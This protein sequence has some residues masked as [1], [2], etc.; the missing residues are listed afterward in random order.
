[1]ANKGLFSSRCGMLPKADARNAHGAP[2]YAFAPKHALAQYAA[3][4]CLN[5]TFYASA[6]V[7]L[8]VMLDLCRSVDDLFLARTALF[9]RE[10]GYMTDMPALLCALLSKRDVA[11]LERVFPRVIDN[12]KMLRNFV[13]M[14][15]SGVAG[16]RS[17]GS[18]PR[19]MVRRFLE[20]RDDDTLF[21]SSAGEDPSLADIVALAHPKP[22]TPEREAL[23]AY[24][25]GWAR[26]SPALPTLVKQYEAFKDGDSLAVPPVPME[27]LTALPLGLDDWRT[28]ARRASWQATRMNLSAFARHGVFGEEGRAQTKAEKEMTSL[29]ADRLRDRRAIRE[30]RALPYQLMVAYTSVDRRIP[31]E[32]LEALQDAMEVAL[33]N[34]PAFDGKVYVLPDVSGSMSTPVTGHRKGATSVVRCRDVAAL[35][36]AAVLRKNPRAEVLPFSDQTVEMALNPRDS[37]ATNAAKLAALPSGGTSCSAPLVTLN[38]RRAQGELVIFVSDNESWV[39]AAGSGPAT[40]VMKQW[41]VFKER[42]PKARLVC[43]DLQPNRTTQ[44]LGREDIL[45]VGGFSDQVFATIAAFAAGRSG[46]GHWVAEIEKVK[47]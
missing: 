47:V 35:V 24:L 25:R 42:S 20:S 1:M 36:A 10:R 11:L 29:V 16:R 43:V 18:A 30:A 22:R 23:Y 21:R 3:T 46:D 26:K 37:V 34:V 6:D 15:R 44:A 13:Q 4:G 14:V 9:A 17:L 5:A 41:A 31:A 7:Q 8:D 28:L 40:E 45:N 32:V 39:D 33:E 12:A 38:G 2:A 19:R 27:M